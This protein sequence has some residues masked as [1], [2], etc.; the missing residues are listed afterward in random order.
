[1]IFSVLHF[2]KFASNASDCTD[3]SLDFQNFPGGEGGGHASRPSLKF[4]SS[5]YI[6]NSRLCRRD[7]D[8]LCAYSLML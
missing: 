8:H 2:F 1:M 5:V 3:F 7:E 6:S 4:P